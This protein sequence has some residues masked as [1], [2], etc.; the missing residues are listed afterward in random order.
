MFNL[1][2][3][4]VIYLCF[5]TEESSLAFSMHFFLARN[6]VCDTPVKPTLSLF[7]STPR[8]LCTFSTL[9]YYTRWKTEQVGEERWHK[10]QWTIMSN[11][12]CVC[13]SYSRTWCAVWFVAM[14]ETHHGHFLL[15][16][17]LLQLVRLLLC[18]DEAFLYIIHSLQR[19]GQIRVMVKKKKTHIN[20]NTTKK[21]RHIRIPD[22]RNNWQQAGC[23]W[24]ESLLRWWR[25]TCAGWGR[26]LGWLRYSSVHTVC[27]GTRWG[28]AYALTKKWWE[29]QREGENEIPF[30]LE[31]VP[32]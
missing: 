3:V 10:T 8:R 5:Q 1:S 9:L 26:F 32:N 18:F 19:Q 22:E 30:L 11:S 24:A 15:L 20:K 23:H 31:S 29:K 6:L 4:R 12:I 14:W 2:T 27:G 13:E 28:Q 16:C 17:Q 25:A 7:T 21:N